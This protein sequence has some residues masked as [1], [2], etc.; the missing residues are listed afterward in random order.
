MRAAT[1]ESMRSNLTSEKRL[2]KNGRLVTKHVKT[3][4]GINTAARV[5][6]PPALPVAGSRKDVPVN[7]LTDEELV[8]GIEDNLAKASFK[9]TPDLRKHFVDDE[10]PSYTI[11]RLNEAV[12]KA[13]EGI[14]E[15]GAESLFSGTVYFN[16]SK[17]NQ[18]RKG[19][20]AAA[21]AY[22]V[23]R[24][25]DDASYD[26]QYG[27][28]QKNNAWWIGQFTRNF[29]RDSLD[30]VYPEDADIDDLTAAYFLDRIG[31]EE[32]F[33]SGTTGSYYRSLAKISSNEDLKD[34]YPIL[35]SAHLVKPD[36]YYER[37]DDVLWYVE[38][39]KNVVPADKA[40]DVAREF[41]SR[42]TVDFNL[43]EEIVNNSSSAVMDGVL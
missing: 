6:P 38:S 8:T 2:D 20:E 32:D 22:P 26:G 35:I 17:A 25:V 28:A 19:L 31:F 37:I 34:Y 33:R 23:A 27:T 11:R 43:A 4:D 29:F 16:R 18:S 24:M 30:D 41:M 39:L 7:E 21:K 15:Q 10:A 3:D 13:T 1:V 5:M 36:E 42:K 40:G 14:D 12:Y 9:L